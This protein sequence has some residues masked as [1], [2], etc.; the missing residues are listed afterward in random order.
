MA[1]EELKKLLAVATDTAISAKIRTKTIEVIGDIATH[2]AL[3]A[4][5]ELAGNDRLAKAERELA[6]KYARDIVRT[7]R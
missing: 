3:L 6:L 1:Q 7:G 5:L 2:E 4:L